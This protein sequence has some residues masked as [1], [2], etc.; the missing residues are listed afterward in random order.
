M[1]NT[2]KTVIVLTTNLLVDIINISDSN[3]SSDP[4]FEIVKELNQHIRVSRIQCK[5]YVE[6]IVSSY[7]DM[8]FKTPYLIILLDKCKSINKLNK[9]KNYKLKVRNI[10][11]I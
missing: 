4:D 10:N 3:D 2:N 11:T 7:S 8:I 6:N 5:N 1:M 9:L